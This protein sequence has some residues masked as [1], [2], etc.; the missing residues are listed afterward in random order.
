M[1]EGSRACGW[2]E[3]VMQTGSPSVCPK[4][5]VSRAGAHCPAGTLP[6]GLLAAKLLNEEN[7]CRSLESLHAFEALKCKGLQPLCTQHCYARYSSEIWGASG[8]PA[9]VPA[10]PVTRAVCDTALN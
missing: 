9:C 5:L 4:G 6:S 3:H 2:D 10:F 7:C 1:Q 8:N